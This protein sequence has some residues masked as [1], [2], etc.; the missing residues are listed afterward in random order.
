[1]SQIHHTPSSFRH[2]IHH[3]PSSFR[4]TIHMAGVRY[5]FIR[6]QRATQYMWSQ[7]VHWLHRQTICDRAICMCMHCFAK[8]DN[9]STLHESLS[10]TSAIVTYVWLSSVTL[11]GRFYCLKMYG[12][13]KGKGKGHPRTDHEGPEGEKR[14]SSTLSL[15]S[16]LDEGGWST[17]RPGRFTPREWPRTHCTRGWVGPRASLDGCWKFRPHRDSIPGPSSS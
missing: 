7:L 3:T 2:T 12:R 1:V 16:A 6:T 15:T 11:P 13:G 14:Y 4:H 10:V 5:C 9:F 17:S 8:R